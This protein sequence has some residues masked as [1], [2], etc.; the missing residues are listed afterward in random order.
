[1]KNLLKKRILVLGFVLTFGWSSSVWAADWP[2]FHFDG[3]S[4]FTTD[5]IGAQ[6]LERWNHPCPNAPTSCVVI[7]GFTYYTTQAGVYKLDSTGALSS[8]WPINPVNPSSLSTTYYTMPAYW[9]S[10]IYVG[11]WDPTQSSKNGV[12]AI[13]TADGSAYWTNPP[14]CPGYCNYNTSQIN[15]YAAPIVGNAGAVEAVFVGDTGGNIYAFDTTKTIPTALWSHNL[16]TMG[17]YSTPAYWTDGTDAWVYFAMV[18]SNPINSKIYKVFASSGFWFGPPFGVHSNPW[19]WPAVG[20]VEG[21]YSSPAVDSSGNVYVGCDNDNV[22]SISLTETMNWTFTAGDVVRSSPA[23]ATLGGTHYVFVGSNDG[24]LYALNANT[25]AQIWNYQ[26]GVPGYAALGAPAISRD[27]LV[28]FGSGSLS[29]NMYIF[30]GN[31]LPST[32]PQVV[33]TVGPWGVNSILSPALSDTTAGG[34]FPA[35]YVAADKIYCLGPTYTLTQSATP[36]VTGTPGPPST[37]TPTLTPLTPFNTPTITVT[38]TCTLTPTITT[39]ATATQTTTMTP[40]ISP[41]STLTLTLTPPPYIIVYPNP[42]NFSQYKGVKIIGTPILGADI[43]IYTISGE[44]VRKVS[45]NTAYP[46][47]WDGNNDDGVPVVTGLYLYI[48]NTAD[49]NSIKG[50]LAI[51]R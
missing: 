36:T 38:F 39:T 27:G 48:I 9:N 45:K 28:Y 47:I 49:G 44:T 43:A 14:T 30:Q 35:A 4:G 15:T 12:Y 50:K 2:I 41:T 42:M 22:Y 5:S 16:G 11:A 33:A 25:G 19:A 17:L 18:A 29:A 32:T 34:G 21:F 46:F 40:T 1:M 26:V 6:N 13:K 10:V 20:T 31:P 37:S 23:V 7:N 24:N 3:S 51:I 8:T